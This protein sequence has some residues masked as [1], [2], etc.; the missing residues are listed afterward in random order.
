[1]VLQDFTILTCPVAYADKQTFPNLDIVGW[2]STGTGIDTD[3]VTIHR[4][5]RSDSS[6][7]E[8][9]CDD[10]MHI[11]MQVWNHNLARNAGREFDWG[12]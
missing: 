8:L 10:R 11:Y 5:A 3:D 7:R 9:A 12:Y 2:Y 1:M 4:K 6:C